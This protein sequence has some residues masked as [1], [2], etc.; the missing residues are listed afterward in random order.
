M[1][2]ND[3]KTYFAKFLLNYAH[4]KKIESL[5]STVAV[6]IFKLTDFYNHFRDK[7]GNK[8]RRVCDIIMPKNWRMRKK[9]WLSMMAKITL[10][11]QRTRVPRN[12]SWPTSRRVL[13]WKTTCR[14][15]LNLFKSRPKPQVCMSASWFTLL[16]ISTRRPT[17]RLIWMK[18]LQRSSNSCMR[19]RVMNSWSTVSWMIN[20]RQS[21][22]KY[23]RK[24]RETTKKLKMTMRVQMRA[25]KLPP[26]TRTSSRR[27][28]IA[29]SPRSSVKLACTSKRCPV[30]AA[31]W[32]CL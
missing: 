29:T 9:R 17:I 30:S 19:P 1:K 14:N 15:S 18:R 2:P 8:K 27:S 28:S 11:P 16:G 22:T 7:T 6:T 20:R 10:K 23:S 25:K 13:T 3:P 5:V 24:V 21:P 12:I 32:P 4:E 31:S 26:R